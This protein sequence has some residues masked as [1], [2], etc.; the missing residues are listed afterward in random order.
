MRSPLLDLEHV[1]FFVIG[2]PEF[3]RLAGLTLRRSFPCRTVWGDK[4]I[5][6]RRLCKTTLSWS[7][8]TRQWGDRLP[9]VRVVVMPQV[10]QLVCQKDNAW[11]FN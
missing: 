2:L 10:L 4:I 11:I 3:I 5:W 7:F 1:A 9:F 8:R 6:D